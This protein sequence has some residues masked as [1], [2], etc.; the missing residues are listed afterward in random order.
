MY[1]LCDEKGLVC[2]AE[3]PV[4]QSY[5]EAAFDNAKQQLIELIRQNY[6]HPSILF[7][8][9]H[10][11]APIPPQQVKILNVMAKKEDPQR[12]TTAASPWTD[13]STVTDLICWNRY[14]G[15]YDPLWDQTADIGSTWADPKHK[16]Q[17]DLKFGVSEYGGGGCISHQKQ[18]PERPDPGYGKF[19]PEQNQTWIHE[20]IWP[21]MYKRRFLWCKYIWNGFDFTVPGWNRG[22]RPNLNHKGLVT[23]DR[24]TKKDAFIITKPIGQMRRWYI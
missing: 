1:R 22:D 13:T 6:N 11:E 23:Y 17:P 8:G 14:P 2:W 7:I 21:D 4:T 20:Q 16:K 3:I 15:W 5:V 24:K 10:N 12:L 18:N 9:L 19:F